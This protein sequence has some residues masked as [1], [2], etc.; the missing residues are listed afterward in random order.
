MNSSKNPIAID[1]FIASIERTQKAIYFM[2]AINIFLLLIFAEIIC[3]YRGV[4]HTSLDIDIPPYASEAFLPLLLITLLLT[5]ISYE[6]AEFIH[7]NYL[8]PLRFFMLIY[9]I[10]MI[11]Y[12]VAEF[13][14]GMILA[15]TNRTST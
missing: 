14:A 6:S 13:I 9:S 10:L 4:C 12:T 15:D 8:G 2:S 5:I 7:I 11:G 1:P 3:L